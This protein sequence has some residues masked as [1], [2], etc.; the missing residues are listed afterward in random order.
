[1]SFF[2]QIKS[3]IGRKSDS[4]GENPDSSSRER[5]RRN[6]RSSHKGRKILIIDDS[7]TVVA[8]LG[9]ILRSANAI[10]YEAFDAE[11]G[12]ELAQNKR[13]DVIFLDIIL[14]RM[15]GFSALRQ[16][17]RDDSMRDIPVIMV[18]GNEYATEQFYAKRIGAD[19]FM[20][21]PF[22]R[23]EIFARLDTLIAAGKLADLGEE[24]QE[25]GSSAAAPKNEGKLRR[26]EKPQPNLEA[27]RRSGSAIRQSDE[28]VGI[29]PLEARSQL[30]AMGLE[31]FNQ[32]Q[33]AAAVDRG[34]KLA[35]DL[36]IVGGGVRVDLHSRT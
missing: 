35:V 36:F 5:R 17:R 11:T 29:T 24:T 4:S 33:F 18:S 20:K 8:A 21:K 34:D 13:P 3:A 32:E 1:M 28:T 25:P 30:T 22:S 2:E 14:P 10:V 31:Y 9:K 19:D 12:L 6:R 7:M 16:I 23:H 27:Y 15:N 26:P